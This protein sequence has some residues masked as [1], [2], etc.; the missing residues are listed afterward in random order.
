M[1]GLCLQIDCDLPSGATNKI[2]IITVIATKIAIW[3]GTIGNVTMMGYDV[4]RMLQVFVARCYLVLP[5]VVST[6]KHMWRGYWADSPC[7]DL[8]AVMRTRLNI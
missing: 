3:T 4:A 1:Q 8:P 5:H 2:G 7:P 6:C